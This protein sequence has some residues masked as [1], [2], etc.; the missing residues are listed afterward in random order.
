VT[1]W[2]DGFRLN[3]I[4]LG[5]TAAWM[6]ALRKQE[7]QCGHWSKGRPPQQ[8]QQYLNGAARLFLTP[9]GVLMCGKHHDQDRLARRRK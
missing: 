9:D 3:M 6:T 4:P 8:C 1:G 7:G 5:A 2:E